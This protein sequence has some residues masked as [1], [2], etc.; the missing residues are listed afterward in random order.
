[1]NFRPRNRR[2]LDVHHIPK[3]EV[4]M[5]QS[6]YIDADKHHSEFRLMENEKLKKRDL[7]IQ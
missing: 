1:M 5:Y 4:Y 3:P 7:I 2:S 6:N